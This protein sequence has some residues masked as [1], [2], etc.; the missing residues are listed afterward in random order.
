MRMKYIE[1]KNEDICE[2]KIKMAK[3]VYQRKK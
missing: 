3:C 1:I 2:M